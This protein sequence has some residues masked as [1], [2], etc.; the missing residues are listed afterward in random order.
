MFV[1]FVVVCRFLAIFIV[2]IYFYCVLLYVVRLF[3]RWL[4]VLRTKQKRWMMQLS[5]LLPA[6]F[7]LA[8]ARCREFN[9]LLYYEKNVT[10]SP[11]NPLPLEQSST[12]DMFV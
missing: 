6:S 8:I 12:N 2:F 10:V 4:T 5:K 3:L 1:V 9:N 11:F 7:D